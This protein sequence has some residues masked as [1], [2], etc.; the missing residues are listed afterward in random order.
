MKLWIKAIKARF[1]AQYCYNVISPEYKGLHVCLTEKDALGWI[2][3]YPKGT[4]WIVQPK[5]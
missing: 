2:E 3:C 4:A 1:S 5:Y